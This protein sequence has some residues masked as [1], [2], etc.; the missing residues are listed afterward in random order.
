MRAETRERSRPS[1]NRSNNNLNL[2]DILSLFMNQMKILME[3]QVDEVKA[4]VSA[5]TQR[6]DHLFSYLKCNNDGY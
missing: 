2:E 5:N 1:T 3:R 6:I 4:A